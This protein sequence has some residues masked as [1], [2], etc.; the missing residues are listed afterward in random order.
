ME[1]VKKSRSYKC[2]PSIGC[3]FRQLSGRSGLHSRLPLDIFG[4]DLYGGKLAERFDKNNDPVRSPV[5]IEGSDDPCEWTIDHKYQISFGKIGT[6]GDRLLRFDHD[7]QGFDRF[8]GNRDRALFVSDQ[9][10]SPDGFDDIQ[11]MIGMKIT[12]HKDIAGKQ[13]D[14]DHFP[15]VLALTG[16]GY[17]RQEDFD[18]FFQKSFADHILKTA[19]GMQNIPGGYQLIENHSL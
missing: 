11:M 12:S 18:R 2:I 15:S 17:F 4:I 9:F 6:G 10:D 8:R 1:L 5:V 16:D 14:P 19:S 3:Y 13:G 7:A